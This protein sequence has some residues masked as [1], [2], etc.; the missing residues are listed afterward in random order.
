MQ[1]GKTFRDKLYEVIFESDTTAGKAFDVTLLFMIVASITSICLESIPSLYAEYPNTFFGLEV[2]FTAIFTLE[3]IL[4][5]IAVRKP[6]NYVKSFY[7]ITDLLAI[8]P[9]YFALIFPSLH[10][11]VVI[12]ALRL[13]RLFRIFKLVHFLNE[14]LFLV[15]A[16]WNARRKILVFFFAVILMTIIAGSLMYVIEHNA[17]QDFHSIPQSIYWAIVTLTTVGY[18]DI[19]PITPLGK[20]LASFIM[21]LGYSIIA[22]PTGIISASL[23]KES[24]NEKVSAQTCPNCMQ[25]GHE[26]NAVFCKYCGHKL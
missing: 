7:G 4:R 25:Q 26:A 18:G 15:N 1:Q 12:R 9:S 10:F 22:V 14:S 17:N 21:L 5:L 24:S 16:L 20:I 19:S 13:L 11:L 8:V 3:Y 23:V 6:L 2:F